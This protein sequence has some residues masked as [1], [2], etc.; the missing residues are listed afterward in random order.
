MASIFENNIGERWLLKHFVPLDTTG[1][2]GL[3]S[4]SMI[5]S[6]HLVTVQPLLNITVRL[7]S[8]LDPK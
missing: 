2:N 1:M 5:R 7:I 4:Y 6:I 3:L 8:D